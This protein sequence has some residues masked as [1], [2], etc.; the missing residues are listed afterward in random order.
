MEVADEGHES[1]WTKPSEL[2]CQSRERTAGRGQ[3]A[4][5]LDIRGYDSIFW[6]P[7]NWTL[8]YERFMMI[9]KPCTNFATGYHHFRC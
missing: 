1:H 2:R 6:T 4:E 3:N 8:R 7:N 9:N 5:D